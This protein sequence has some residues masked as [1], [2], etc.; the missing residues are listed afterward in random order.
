EEALK[1]I[2]FV[3]EKLQPNDASYLIDRPDV[4]RA[5]NKLAEA[6][7]DCQ[8]SIKLQ[9]KQIEAYISL[10]LIYEKQGKP[11]LAKD[12]YDRM[13]APDP[14]SLTAYP[15]RAEFRRNREQ[16]EEALADCA[17]A[18]KLAPGSALPSLVAASVKAAR[19]EHE[20]AVRE[21]NEALKR[22]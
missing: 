2:N 5:L 22:A 8:R 6:A 7:A 11:D 4:Y 10:A 13:V 14:K 20:Q 17:E 18:T 19:G 15:Q 16:F 12:C 9:P 21:A 1:D 3:V